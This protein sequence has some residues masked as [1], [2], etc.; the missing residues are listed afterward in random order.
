MLCILSAIKTE[1]SHL[2]DLLGAER[3]GDTKNLWKT[4]DDRILLLAGGIGFLQAA[5]SLQ[6]MFGKFPE[7]DQ[8]VFCGSA[9]V[10]PGEKD[11]GVGDVV[12]CRDTVLC[13]GAAELELSIYATIMSRQPIQSSLPIH[14]VGKDG[15]VATILSLT[16]NDELA[17]TIATNNECDLEN[18]ELYGL[19]SVCRLKSLAWNAVLGV[20]NVVGKSGHQEWKDN[21]KTMARECC[22]ALYRYVVPPV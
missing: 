15:R 12:L 1:I 14:T 22:E 18:M 16:C 17:K 20:T 4:K 21:Y 10:Y 11:F 6:K 19:A 13:D 8:V 3:F 5:V 2:I 9:G 7:I